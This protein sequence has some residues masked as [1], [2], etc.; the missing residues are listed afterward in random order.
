MRHGG[1]V[2]DRR[3]GPGMM[4][5]LGTRV[6]SRTRCEWADSGNLSVPRRGITDGAVRSNH[7]TMVARLHSC[8]RW[9]LV[10]ARAV[11]IRDV[12][13]RRGI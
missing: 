12:R 11:R 3:T 7:R 8:S 4:K 10:L 13:G 9:E 2:R 6:D 1:R 5:R